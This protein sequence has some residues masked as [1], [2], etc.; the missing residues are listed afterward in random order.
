[1]SLLQFFDNHGLLDLRNRPQW[2]T[3]SGG[4]KRYVARMMERFGATAKTDAAV[5]AV[6][7]SRSLSAAANPSSHTP[8][9]RQ[10][11]GGSSPSIRRT[12]LVAI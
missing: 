6:S 5:S 2:R 1:M 11:A 7:G 3:V 9:R 4:S 12:R 8:G 10:S